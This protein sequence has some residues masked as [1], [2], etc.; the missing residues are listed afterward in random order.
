MN[1]IRSNATLRPFP[2]GWLVAAL[3]VASGVLW[4]VMFF[5][6]LAYL[7]QLAGGAAP[8]DVRP[9]LYSEQEARAFLAAI[10]EQGRT[11]YGHR[12]LLLDSIY[13]PL[14]AVSRGL[15]LWWL[16]MPRRVREAP[17]PR[18]WRHALIAV[19]IVMASLDMIENVC[20]ARMLSAWPAL[21]PGLV[22]ISSLATRLKM[23]AGA[24]TEL[25]MAVLAA[26]WLLRLARRRASRRKI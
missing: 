9:F 5:G 22:H 19:P 13:P 15:A 18:G 3:L 14:Y 8:F 10:G 7:A 25:S 21:S 26:L 20:I 1:L 6:P 24:L 16:T 4:A 23:M 17:L 2:S 12:E 11:F